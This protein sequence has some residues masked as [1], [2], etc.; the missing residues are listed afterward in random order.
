MANIDRES[1]AGLQE[2]EPSPVEET[3]SQSKDGYFP[4]PDSSPSTT[5][6]G[7][8]HLGLQQHSSIWYLSRIQKYSS[9]VFSAFAAA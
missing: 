5:S 4:P 8:H 1:N 2:L 7:T 6:K 3:P 9:Y